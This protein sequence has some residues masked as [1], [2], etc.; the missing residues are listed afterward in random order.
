ME[1][2]TPKSKRAPTAFANLWEP[3]TGEGTLKE[4]GPEN[5]DEA[6]TISPTEEGSPTSNIK[7]L[8]TGIWLL[9]SS[10]TQKETERRQQ[11]K[12]KLKQAALL[13]KKQIN[14]KERCPLE[15]QK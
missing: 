13:G 7:T 5:T 15:R 14:R 1:K 8:N 6:Q 11:Q 9:T 10:V 3:D 12:R 2:S 4:K